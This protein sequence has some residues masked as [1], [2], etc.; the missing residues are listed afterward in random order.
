MTPLSFDYPISVV[1]LY[2]VDAEGTHEA[3]VQMAEA[4]EERGHVVRL[5]RVTR[6]NWRQAVRVPGDVVLNLAEDTDWKLYV[7]VGKAL[8][9]LGRAQMGHDLAS[10]MFAINK[11]VVKR[12]LA[13]GGLATPKFRILSRRGARMVRGL[14]YPLMVKPA[15]HHASEGISQDSVVID[16]K[17]LTERVEYLWDRFGGEVVVEEFIEGDEV[18]VAVMGNGRR[19]VVLPYVGIVYKG[20]FA[21]NWNVFTYKAKW[22]K[23]SWEYWYSK[24][25]CPVSW[26]RKTDERIEK[27]AVAV[28]KMFGCRD[29][30][31]FDIKVTDEGKPYILDMNLNPSLSG[32]DQ[33]ECWVSMK[34][35]G[36]TYPQM[37]ETIVAITYKRVYGKLPSRLRERQLLLAAG[38]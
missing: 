25:I 4:L 15:G 3:A 16:E 37:M 28:Y 26:G 29:V 21:D 27:L 6:K 30:A 10:F 22:D 18:H 13:A 12:K 19:V 35:L 7:K 36:W 20:E 33:D 5:F 9:M 23:S 8:E 31:R 24:L 17:E 34:A 2:V 32:D 14:E 11:R 38:V 1:V